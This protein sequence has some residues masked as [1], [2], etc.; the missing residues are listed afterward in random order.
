MDN[1]S[2]EDHLKKIN[3]W[4]NEKAKKPFI[5]EVCGHKDWG[6]EEYIVTPTIIENNTVL[7]GGKALPQIV[8]VCNHCGNIKYFS[9][10]KMGLI[11]NENK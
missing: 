2:K 11:T 4:F 1:M 9:A 6:V 10:V 5:C 7:V 8:L 3:Q